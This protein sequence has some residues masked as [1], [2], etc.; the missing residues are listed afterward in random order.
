MGDRYNI[1]SQVRFFVIH[2]IYIYENNL[3]R[4]LLFITIF[5]SDAPL[6]IGLSFCTPVSNIVTH[7]QKTDSIPS[8]LLSLHPLFPLVMNGSMIKL[9]HSL[10]LLLSIF[11][12]I[13][14][15]FYLRSY[16][17]SVLIAYLLCTV[18]CVQCTYLISQ[19]EFVIKFLA[20][21]RYTNETIDVCRW[22]IC[23]P[24]TWEPDTGT[25][26]SSSGPPTST[27]PLMLFTM[28]HCRQ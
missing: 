11:I 3:L 16:C 22:S 18:C 5:R 28:Y 10:F 12:L 4:S 24:S 1:L 15:S 17:R 20:H 7:F 21:I 23:S 14:V 2:I 25:P 26:P 27:G 19:Q 6:E 13:S 8:P 9:P